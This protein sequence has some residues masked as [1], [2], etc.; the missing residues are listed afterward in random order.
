[1]NALLVIFFVA[2]SIYAFFNNFKF[3]LIYI[4]LMA[5]YIYLTQVR[6]L[7]SS[8]NSLR[9]RIQIATWGAPNDPEIYGKL[10]LDITKME[11]YLEELSK[12]IGEKI[13]I[14]IFVIKLIALAMRKYP[15]FFG[16]IKFGK[17]IL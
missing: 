5:L 16:Y 17:V 4:A 2:Y 1:M 6:F 11:P 14:T 9:K 13:T 10:K 12:E 15:D 8:L 7:N 3:W